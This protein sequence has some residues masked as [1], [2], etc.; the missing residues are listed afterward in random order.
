[1]RDIRDVLNEKS[2]WV[3]VMEAA[4]QNVEVDEGGVG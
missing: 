4:E 3:V 1:M 2:K